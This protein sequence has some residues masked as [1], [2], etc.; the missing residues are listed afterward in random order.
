MF[1]D[2]DDDEDF[3][4][5]I[6]CGLAHRGPRNCGPSLVMNILFISG[7]E[8]REEYVLQKVLRKFLRNWEWQKFLDE[9]G[10]G[11]EHSFDGGLLLPEAASFDFWFEPRSIDVIIGGLRRAGDVISVKFLER[12]KQGPGDEL[13]NTTQAVLK[14]H[15]LAA[16]KKLTN[17]IPRPGRDTNPL[18]HSLDNSAFPLEDS[19]LC[20]PDRPYLGRWKGLAG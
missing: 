16:F 13:G 9:V 18:T 3:N 15:R 12:W 7:P 2:G 10:I 17:L 6:R 5:R 20:L 11:Q 4:P 19:F 1:D 14:E 8:P